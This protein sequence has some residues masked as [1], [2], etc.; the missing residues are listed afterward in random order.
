MGDMA[1]DFRFMKER[2][3]QRRERNLRNADPEGWTEH[4]MH[5]WSRT[6]AG[7][8]LDYW[9]SRNKFQYDKGRVMTGDV[10]GFI[11]NMEKKHAR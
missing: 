5:H 9:P 6:V 3:K 10:L 1:D 11:R 8:R 7:K 2:D 4:T